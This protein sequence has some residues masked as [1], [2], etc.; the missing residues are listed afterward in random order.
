MAE[1]LGAAAVMVTPSKEGVPLADDRMMEYYGK[2]DEG[3]NIPIVL[4][5]HP[6]ST[7]VRAAGRR[8]REGEGDSAAPLCYPTAAH[9]GS[10]QPLLLNRPGQ[11]VG[12]AAGPAGQRHPVDQVCQA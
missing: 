9:S 2:I 5:D 8:R 4:Q 7:L 11:H 10:K 3:I 12:P 6:A 1:E